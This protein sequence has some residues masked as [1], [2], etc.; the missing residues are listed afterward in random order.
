MLRNIEIRARVTRDLR[1][2][3]KKDAAK[4]LNAI[5]ALRSG[6]SGDVKKLTNYSPSYRLRIGIGGGFSTLKAIIDPRTTNAAT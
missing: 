3:P 5:N 6:M 1:A 2:I 4:I